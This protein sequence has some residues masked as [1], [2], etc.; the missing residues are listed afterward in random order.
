[1]ESNPIYPPLA[2]GSRGYAPDP[3][4]EKKKT[5][6]FSSFSNK[7]CEEKNYLLRSASSRNDLNHL[8]IG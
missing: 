5:F 8:A 2:G 6:S 1:M 3:V 7:H 4:E